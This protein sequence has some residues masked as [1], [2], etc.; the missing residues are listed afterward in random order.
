MTLVILLVASV[1]LIVLL[2]TKL[3][4]HA[5]LSLILAALFFGLF[6]G[7]SLELLMQS[8]N[9]GFGETLGK[10]GIVIVLGVIITLSGV[11]SQW[12]MGLWLPFILAASIKTAQGSSTV[13]MI[14]TASIVAP[15]MVSLG[16]GGDMERAIVV[17]AIGAGAA[18]VSHVNDSMFWIF[19]QITGIDVKTG[20]K[21]YT[22]GTFVLGMTAILLLNLIYFFL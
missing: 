19:A 7:M 9:S 4:V 17:V 8:I 5:F 12:N 16:F 6:S 2:S 21:K 3:K 1:A 13:A 15:L 18:V 22:P 10:I 14:T 20:L 11:L